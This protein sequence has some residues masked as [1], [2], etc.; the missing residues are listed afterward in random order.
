M[1]NDSFGKIYYHNDTPLDSGK[2]IKA[3]ANLDQLDLT[4]C[5]DE[6]IITQDQIDDLIDVDFRDNSEDWW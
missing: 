4:G 2:R 1:T 5:Y 6:P 3:K